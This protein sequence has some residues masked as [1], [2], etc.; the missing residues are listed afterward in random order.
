MTRFH[1]FKKVLVSAVLV[2][3]FSALS[4][5]KVHLPQGKTT[6]LRITPEEPSSIILRVFESSDKNDFSDVGAV[7]DPDSFAPRIPF[8]KDMHRFWNKQ[9]REWQLSVDRVRIRFME[10]YLAPA[11]AN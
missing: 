7:S 5:G 9:L 3:L 10:D 2:F 8:P 11:K 6:L 4:P 1:I